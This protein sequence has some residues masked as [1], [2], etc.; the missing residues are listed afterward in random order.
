MLVS[1][2]RVAAWIMNTS[3]RENILFGHRYEE[4]FYK[5]MAGAVSRMRCPHRVFPW[6]VSVSVWMG[7]CGMAP[8]TI[9]A[10][11]LEPDLAMLPAGDMTEIG[12]RGVNLSGG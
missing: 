2:A 9:A 11:A 7:G 12:E 1:C 8:E 4:D 3:V 6:C 10:C 5:G